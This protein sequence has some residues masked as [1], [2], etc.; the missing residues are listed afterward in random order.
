VSSNKFYS[1]QAAVPYVQQ[2]REIVTCGECRFFTMP[3]A[4]YERNSSGNCKKL[5]DWFA[6]HKE[7]GT[8]PTLEKQN[9]VYADTGGNKLCFPN[10]ERYCRY[11]A[12]ILK[13][14]K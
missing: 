10:I 4:Q 8:K 13:L 14:V 2:H 5:S 3:T 1:K 9:A 11:Y 6:K 7:A 12:P